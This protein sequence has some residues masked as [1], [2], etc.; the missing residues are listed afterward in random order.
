[1]LSALTIGFHV[2][3]E[4]SGG[5]PDKVFTVKTDRPET[6]PTN[7]PLAGEPPGAAW[8]KLGKAG[9]TLSKIGNPF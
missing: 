9:T 2:L 8:A 1:L 3:D 7:P 4:K 6:G 5:K